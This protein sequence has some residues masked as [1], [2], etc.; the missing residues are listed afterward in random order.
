MIEQYDKL[1]SQVQSDFE[2]LHPEFF[3]SATPWPLSAQDQIILRADMAFE[4]GSN[5][6][7]TTSGILFTTSSNLVSQNKIFVCKNVLST[8]DCLDADSSVNYVKF[9][10]IKL[11]ESAIKDKSS[12]ELY[13]IFR[14]LDYVRYHVFL[15][16]F[17]IRISSSQ[18]KEIVRIS[19]AA[20]KS[21]ITLQSV[22]QT[23]IN[24]YLKIPQVDSVQIYFA[25]QK[26][27]SP[28]FSRLSKI[29]QNAEQI[30]ESLN[31]IFQGLKMDCSTCGQK[32]ICDQIEGMKELHQNL[33]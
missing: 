21:G 6:A 17:D 1:I 10:I 12:Q 9:V 14:N 7:C 4:L 19:K 23:L 26:E 31:E 5:Q 16:G 11:K 18:H 2:S 3:F 30:T 8:P 24:S 29:A 33:Q 20:V 28:V 15:E 22:G 27:S 13:A 32:S 25:A